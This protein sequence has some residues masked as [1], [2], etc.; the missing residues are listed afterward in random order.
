M[1]GS[2][3][4]PYVGEKRERERGREGESGR[5]GETY[6]LSFFNHL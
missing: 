5:A 1:Q 6:Q 2:G 3:V 4:Y